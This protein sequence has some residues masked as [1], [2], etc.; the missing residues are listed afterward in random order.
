MYVY[1]YVS[2]SIYIYIFGEREQRY[3]FTQKQHNTQQTHRQTHT[4]RTTMHI[5]KTWMHKRCVYIYGDIYIYS[6]I[7]RS[8]AKTRITNTN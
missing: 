6:C 8:N 7:D 4:R 5:T 3:T 1:V 2:L